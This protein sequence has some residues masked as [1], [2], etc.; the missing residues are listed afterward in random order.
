MLWVLAGT[1]DAGEIIARLVEEGFE[2]IASVTTRYGADIASKAG[3]S[4]VVVGQLG[5]EEMLHLLR[6]KSIGAIV[7]ATHPF[8]VEASENAMKAAEE[9]GVVYIRYE[10][11]RLNLSGED[12]HEV[13]G[14]E[15][16][17]R[18]ASE[19]GRVVFYTAGIKNLPTFLKHCSSRVVVRALPF[20][21]VIARII[22][23]GLGPED[24][25]A[26]RPRFDK[27]LNRAM[28]KAYRAEVLVTKESGSEGGVGEKL[29]AARELGIPV[30]VVRRPSLAYPKMCESVEGVVQEI[31]KLSLT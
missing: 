25:I 14:F 4:E 8:A 7:D 28:L 5:K 20:P 21:E 27:E 19:L 13:E 17:A 29:A 12:I 31:K 30:I 10:R 6:S 3:A 24:I 16:A 23:L 18:L 15:E 26:M 1:G 2:V 22:E 11:P 9:A